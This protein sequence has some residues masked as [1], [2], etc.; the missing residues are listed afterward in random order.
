L[1][2]V[3]AIRHEVMLADPLVSL[4]PQVTARASSGGR[5]D[6]RNDLLP[7]GSNS[8]L[9]NHYRKSTFTRPNCAPSRTRTC[10][11]LLRRQKKTV[12]TE[13]LTW[14]DVAFT[15]NDIRLTLPDDAQ[16]LRLLAPRLAPHNEYRVLLPICQLPAPFLVVI[17]PGRCR[18]L[19][20]R[21]GRRRSRTAP[22]LLSPW[23]ALRS[24]GLPAI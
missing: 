1:L 15:C 16:R 10:D 3:Q 17:A 6:L 18:P 24:S 5:H 20:D 21:P 11:L 9:Q 8:S 23:D 22:R 12:A 13:R 19:A 2:P 4:A 14:P 7:M